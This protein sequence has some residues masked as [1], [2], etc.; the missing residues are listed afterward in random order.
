[1]VKARLA[2]RAPASVAV[3]LLL[4]IA[5]CSEPGGTTTARQANAGTS[6]APPVAIGTP[7]SSFALPVAQ[8]NDVAGYQFLGSG[9]VV[10][11]PLAP[12]ST[13]SADASGDISFNFVNASVVAV[14]Q[15]IFGQLLKE[16]YTV[17]GGVQGTITLQTTHPL[18]RDEVIPALETSLQMANLAL[19][20]EADG[21]HIVP[22]ASAAQAGAG[23]ISVAG[24]PQ[25]Q[26][27]GYEV[28]PLQYANA[29]SVQ[30]LIQPLA[31]SGVQMQVD[32]AR[33]LLIIAGTSQQR[34]AIAADVAV[35]DVDW[36]AGMSY[37]LVPLQNTSAA[38]VSKEVGQLINGGSSPMS[39]LVRLVV[40]GQLNSILV[41]SSQARYISEVRNWIGR[42][43]QQGS[44]DERQVFVYRVQNG[45]A[46]D[47]ANTL[48]GL[49]GQQSQG[50]NTNT[51]AAGGGTS[52]GAGA[53]DQAENASGVAGLAA[54]P[55]S[56]MGGASPLLGPV[57]APAN[58]T[59]GQ[60]NSDVADASANAQGDGEDSDDVAPRIIAD[61]TNN[62][63]LI[64]ATPDQYKS[65]ESALVQLDVAPEQVML[66]A[67]VAEVDLTNKLSYGVQYF[68][69]SGRV[70]SINTIGATDALS[71]VSRRS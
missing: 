40:I 68:F 27:Y 64:Y 2:L 59:A 3:M 43:D 6:A 30:A 10:P 24:G 34:A 71:Q 9:A 25:T 21:Y 5:G 13:E 15:T 52:D 45:K 16:N 18:T 29:S 61:N 63:L 1:M 4:G 42:F 60:N 44:S 58:A 22:L 28:I 70:Q 53:S 37:A 23:N 17:D 8:N 11:P 66:E 47:I 57:Q 49:L 35:F 46:Q 33:N 54:S 12:A 38:A 51:S 36:L 55:S 31:Q 67:V 56:Q 65:L 19:T 20:H 48:N 7:P 26:G 32:A 14:A 62:A 50:N 69:Q 41:V 39:G